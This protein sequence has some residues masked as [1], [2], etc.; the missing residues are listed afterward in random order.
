[1]S[2]IPMEKEEEKTQ[3]MKRQDSNSQTRNELKK[4]WALLLAI[5]AMIFYY[6]GLA[7]AMCVRQVD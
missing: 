7:G 4:T 3:E 5:F 2:E 6:P 1:M